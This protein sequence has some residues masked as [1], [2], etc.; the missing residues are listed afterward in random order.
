[1]V[2]TRLRLNRPRAPMGDTTTVRTRPASVGG[3]LIL[4]VG[5]APG[6]EPG[7]PTFEPTASDLATP[8]ASAEAAASA[9]TRLEASVFAPGTISSDAEE[10]RI[11]FTPDGQ[12]AY[13]ARGTGFFPA[14]R[15]ATILETRLVD[16]A[17]TEPGPA[18]FS[19]TYP[20]IDPWIS[21]DGASL[22]F[23]SIRPVE[24]QERSDAEVWRVDRVGD[25]WSDPVHLAAVG[26]DADELGASVTDDGTLWL[27][28]DRGGG[29]WDLYTAAPEGEGFASPTPVTELNTGIWEFNP[30]I[31]PDGNLLVFTSIGRVDGSGLGD[32]FVANRSDGAWS[33]AVASLINSPADEYH[34][35]FSPD[36]ATL[37]FV[38]RAGDGDLYKIPWPGP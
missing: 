5:C 13:F 38:R 14:S 12:T 2:H 30:A 1:M 3:I 24:G 20:D 26:S 4:L 25:G 17:W 27:A 34:A 22:Y 31:S 28:S 10:Y 7:T 9:S 11:T 8:S 23:S 19:G 6:T 33:E 21:P 37:Y 15:R 35:S 16:G 18:S 36:G 29:Q 32:L